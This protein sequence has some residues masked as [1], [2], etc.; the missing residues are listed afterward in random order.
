M[1]VQEFSK[2]EEIAKIEKKIKS[3]RLIESCID[4]AISLGNGRT[5]VYDAHT[6]NRYTFEENGLKIDYE[7]GYNM[8]G[9]G[10][11][12]VYA[13]KENVLYATRADVELK[14]DLP[15]LE[16]THDFKKRYQIEKYLPGD[17][18]KQVAKLKRD[19]KK[20]IKKRIRDMWQI[21]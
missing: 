12:K 14:K 3:S 6:N 9:G 21:K 1:A 4:V 13:E 7:D 17:W 19:K 10:H 16:I 18:E 5:A 15:T 20:I 8:F 2:L 11:L